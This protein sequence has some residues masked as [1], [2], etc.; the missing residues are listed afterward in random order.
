MHSWPKR[1]REVGSANQS[2]VH[3]ATSNPNTEWNVSSEAHYAPLWWWWVNNSNESQKLPTTRDSYQI[4]PFNFE[5][6]FWCWYIRKFNLY[7]L[8]YKK[9]EENPFTNSCAKRLRRER[10]WTEKLAACCGGYS[11]QRAW[12]FTVDC[13]SYRPE[14]YCRLLRL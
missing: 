2:R 4:Y 10:S 9:I 1:H 12:K 14:H 6:S 5:I 11:M 7:I 13:C 3:F 8:Q